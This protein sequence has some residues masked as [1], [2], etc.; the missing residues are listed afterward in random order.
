VP[1]VVILIVVGF[2]RGETMLQ[3]LVL[4]LAGVVVAG[5]A[6]TAVIGAAANESGAKPSRFEQLLERV[7]RL[8]ARVAELE[9]QTRVLVVPRA[10]APAKPRGRVPEGWVEKEFNGVPY[11]I[12][13]CDE[14]DA[15]VA[16]RK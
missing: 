14:K 16:P 6:T 9:K 1:S 13:P 11:Y 2:G 3:R 15:A 7:E 12:V 4:V 10:T 5:L 8:E